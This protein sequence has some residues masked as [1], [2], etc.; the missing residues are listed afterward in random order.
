MNP[1]VPLSQ[2]SMSQQRAH[3]LGSDFH[4]HG[5]IVKVDAELCRL[6]DKMT[7][8]ERIRQIL[9]EVQPL[10]EEIKRRAMIYQCEEKEYAAKKDGKP[11]DAY[12][13]LPYAEWS[14]IRDRSGFNSKG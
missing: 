14:V 8:V 9:I 2:Q 13:H 1:I 3:N 10:R 11:F 7:P 6:W 4:T 5:E 12:H